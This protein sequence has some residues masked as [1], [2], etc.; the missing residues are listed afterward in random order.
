[1][2]TEFYHFDQ[3]EE[4]AR[5]ASDYFS[6]SSGYLILGELEERK[7]NFDRAIAYY[8]QSTKDNYTPLPLINLAKIY[9][10]M[11]HWEQAERY[12]TQIERVTDYSWIANFGMSTAQFY[13]E[14]YGLYQ[15]LYEKKY[16]AEK[17][18]IPERAKDFFVRS[19]NLTKYSALIRYYRAAFSIHNLKLAKEYTIADTDDNTH[20]LY[21]N[22][23]YYRAFQ[24]VPFKA[25]RYLRRAEALE[26]SVIPQ[27]R[28]SYIA[29]KGILLRDEQLLREALDALD[30]VWE[31][32]LREQTAAELI[33][34][35][36]NTELK[37]AL[38]QE[39]L[40]SNPACF[41]E[42]WIRLPVTLSC[43][44]SD[45]RLSKQT[46]KRI[47]AALNKSLFTVSKHAPFSIMAVCTE[48]GIRL[49][50][51]GQDGSIYSRYEHPAPVAD[52][53]EAA[54]CVNRFAAQLFRVAVR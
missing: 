19:K 11:G 12:I 32:E 49:S 40:Q 48:S 1:M 20:G 5:N 8:A 45:E 2:E 34:C 36:K 42:H 44:G 17:M 35:T 3:A 50:L 14:L 15:T 7:N 10:R 37:T 25:R 9:L 29:E 23:F 6:R 16:A 46:E 51:I 26:T 54:T 43:T 33:L 38:Y 27:A 22:S 39:L 24:S 47:A 18:R 30:P 13:T 53:Q 41:P 21:K 28:P 52:K 4:D 31:K